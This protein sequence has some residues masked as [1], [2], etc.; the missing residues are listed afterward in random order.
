MEELLDKILSVLKYVEQ[1]DEIDVEGIPPCNHVL[2]HIS[3]V[4]REDEV[5]KI[6]KNERLSQEKFL[7]NSPSNVGGMIKVPPVIKF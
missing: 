4:F 7:K 6:E 5:G 2:E 3:N 1:I